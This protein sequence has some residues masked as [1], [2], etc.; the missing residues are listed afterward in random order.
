MSGKRTTLTRAF[1]ASGAL[2]SRIR[3]IRAAR[4]SNP[5]ELRATLLC[6]RGS[7]AHRRTHKQLL[8]R[9]VRSAPV[10]AFSS[11]LLPVGLG[12]GSPLRTQYHPLSSI[13]HPVGVLAGTPQAL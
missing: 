10:L 12:Y 1:A 4:A 5:P 2:S 3:R 13:A 8:A 11:L 6:T 9:I 7:G